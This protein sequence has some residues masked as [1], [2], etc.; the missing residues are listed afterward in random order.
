MMR[1]ARL[2]NVMNHSIMIENYG[3][4][5]VMEWRETDI[6]DPAINLQLAGPGSLK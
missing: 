6:P 2:E 3:G 1:T 4:P 5:E